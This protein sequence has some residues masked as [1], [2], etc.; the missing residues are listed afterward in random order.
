M[1]TGHVLTRRV[2][3]SSL[4]TRSSGSPERLGSRAPVLWRALAHV[5]LGSWALAA[6]GCDRVMVVKGTV[7]GQHPGLERQPV[8]RAMVKVH[9]GSRSG[10]P[11]PAF[12]EVL[13]DGEGQFRCEF[14]GAQPKNVYLT[15]SAP[16]YVPVQTPV[17][18]GQEPP[19]APWECEEQHGRCWGLDVV[20]APQPWGRA[21]R[22]RAPRSRAAPHAARASD[23]SA[24]A[25]ADA[26][27]GMSAAGRPARTRCEA[28]RLAARPGHGG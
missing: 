4:A 14:M 2:R 6:T 12:Q 26:G 19:A 23:G 28:H 3:G 16:G 5:F 11:G 25:P 8:A 21:R 1:A 17:R 9:N 15:F 24:P 10:Q 13:A 7:W 27:A 22:C 20:L 18:G